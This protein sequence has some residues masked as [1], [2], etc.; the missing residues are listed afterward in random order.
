MKSAT[1]NPGSALDVDAY[2]AKL[3]S[4]ARTALEGLRAAIQVAAPAATEAF[5]YRSHSPL[6][7]PGVRRD[8]H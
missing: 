2:L 5:S 7:L 4:D 3:P 8:S 1:R 6:A